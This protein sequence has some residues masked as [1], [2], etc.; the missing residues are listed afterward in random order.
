MKN[1]DLFFLPI[2]NATFK[3]PN[4]LAALSVLA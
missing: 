3:A 4:L 2:E 1:G